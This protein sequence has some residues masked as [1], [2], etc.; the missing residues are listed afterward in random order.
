MTDIVTN[1]LGGHGKEG[2][3]GRGW[4]AENL[5]KFEIEPIAL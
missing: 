2:E 4:Q 5:A 1:I 3:G